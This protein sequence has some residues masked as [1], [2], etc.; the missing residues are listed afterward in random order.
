MN[1]LI[2]DDDDVLRHKIVTDL[3]NLSVT[4]YESTNGKAALELLKSN[5]KIDI[6]LCDF[7]MPEMNGIK[8]LEEL[9]KMPSYENLPFYMMSTH[10]DPLIKQAAEKSKYNGWIIKPIDSNTIK[11]LIAKNT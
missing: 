4:T 1:V 10:S 7:N 6:I 8:V 2:I 11:T 3:K 9:R 5:S